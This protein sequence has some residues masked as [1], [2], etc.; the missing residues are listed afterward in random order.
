MPRR[1][2]EQSRIHEISPIVER[3]SMVG[4]VC[5]RD[6]FWGWW[7]WQRCRGVV[8]YNGLCSEHI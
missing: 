5:K 8:S 1:N 7:R 3:W 6:R 4:R 2:N